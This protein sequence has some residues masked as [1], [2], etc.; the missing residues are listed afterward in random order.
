M[1][2]WRPVS[3]LGLGWLFLFVGPLSGGSVGRFC[4]R[5]NDPLRQWLA[6]VFVCFCMV[7]VVFM[8]C[9]LYDLDL[10]RC[11]GAVFYQKIPVVSS[12]IMFRKSTV[13]ITNNNERRF[14]ESRDKRK[15]DFDCHLFSMCIFLIGYQIAH[16]NISDVNLC[17]Q[18]YLL[19]IIFIYRVYN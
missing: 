12:K 17:Q 14:T 5:R 7:C 8:L 16:S 6:R 2:R 10:P 9:M 18:Y 13:V 11:T 4:A 1:A 19:I 15:E 3:R